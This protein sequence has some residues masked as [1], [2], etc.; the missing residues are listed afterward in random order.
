MTPAHCPDCRK[1]NMLRTRPEYGPD[2]LVCENCNCPVELAIKPVS[3]KDIGAIMLCHLFAAIGIIASTADLEGLAVHRGPSIQFLKGFGI[4]MAVVCLF[5]AG[6]M[7][8][9]K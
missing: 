5:I 2:I 6:K 7:A 3:R 1:E 4:V 9:K 8:L